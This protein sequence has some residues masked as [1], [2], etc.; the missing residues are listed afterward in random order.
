MTQIVFENT[1]VFPNW[2]LTKNVINLFKIFIRINAILHEEL[3]K[4]FL[5]D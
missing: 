5:I 1:E 3:K 2:N 4:K